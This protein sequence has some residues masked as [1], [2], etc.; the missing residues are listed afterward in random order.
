M[1]GFGFVIIVSLLTLFVMS[2]TYIQNLVYHERL[3]QMEEVTHQMFR[4][5]EDVI[6]TH[7][8]EVDVQCNY[9][10]TARWRPI[11][12]LPLSEKAVGAFQL[13]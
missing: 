12:T 2:Q 9:C 5:L 11:P 1:V 10:T 3:S 4:S 6:D 7:W 13:P 8:D